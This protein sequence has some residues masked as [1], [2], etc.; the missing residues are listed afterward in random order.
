[1]QSGRAVRLK[2]GAKFPGRLPIPPRDSDQSH[3]A[4]R[5]Q[6]PSGSFNVCWRREPG[7]GN[8]DR[9]E[10][11]RI[12]GATETVEREKLNDERG[13]KP[14]PVSG[15]RDGAEMGNASPGRVREQLLYSSP[16]NQ[17]R[18]PSG[19]ETMPGR[20]PRTYLDSKDARSNQRDCDCE[21]HD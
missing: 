11:D 12:R 17:P 3:Q 18:K 8:T 19:L 5:V 13:G 16:R 14:L 1:M 20:E 2:T 9:P 21:E 4:N 15:R 6:S 10:A 7:C